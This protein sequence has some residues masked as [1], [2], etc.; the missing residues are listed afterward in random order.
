MKHIEQQLQPPAFWH[1]H[2]IKPWNV[3]ARISLKAQIF[4]ANVCAT[5]KGL[6]VAHCSPSELKKPGRFLRW[7]GQKMEQSKQKQKQIK[8]EL[9]F[10]AA[11]AVCKHVYMTELCCV[12]HR[13]DDLGF[14]EILEHGRDCKGECKTVGDRVG[15]HLCRSTTRRK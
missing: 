7:A 5:M 14:R 4:L 1:T 9:C 11:A 13:R 10:H 12:L 6:S 8:Y 15:E 2:T 3:H